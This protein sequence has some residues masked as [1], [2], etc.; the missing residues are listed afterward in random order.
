MLDRNNQASQEKRIYVNEHE[1]AR[2]TGRSVSTLRNERCQ[3]KGMPYYKIGK[4]VRY[5]L[6][7]VY[8]IME[9]KRIERDRF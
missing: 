9:S 7:E 6:S 5:L 1:V 3:C 8:D 4:S 2:I